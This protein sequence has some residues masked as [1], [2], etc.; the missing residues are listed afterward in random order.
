MKLKV[1][2]ENYRSNDCVIRIDDYVDD[3]LNEEDDDVQQHLDEDETMVRL[4][5]IYEEEVDEGDGGLHV[6][7]DSK[8]LP[9]LSKD[10][11][12]IDE[13]DGNS[14][15]DIEILENNKTTT[16]EEEEEE[17]DDDD[18]EK[19]D[20]GEM[21]EKEK[22]DSATTLN[23]KALRPSVLLMGLKKSGKT[24]IKRVVF[25]QESPVNTTHLPPTVEVENNYYEN[26]SFIQLTVT[27]IPGQIELTDEILEKISLC[28][29]LIY[30][31]DAKLQKSILQR[32]LDALVTCISRG[33]ELNTNIRFEILVHKV[34]GLSM[35]ERETVFQFIS[36]EVYRQLALRNIRQIYTNFHLTSIYDYSVFE[37]FSKTIQRIT[38]QMRNLAE[39][40]KILADSCKVEKCFLFDIVSRIY[41]ATDAANSCDDYIF[42]MYSNVIKLCL[43]TTKYYDNKNYN[44]IL[45]EQQQNEESEDKEKSTTTSYSTTSD[46]STGST[47]TTSTKSSDKSKQL[48][49]FLAV[50]RLHSDP[51]RYVYLR[52]VIGSL[53]IACSMKCHTVEQRYLMD[54]NFNHANEAIKKLLESPATTDNELM[55]HP[56]DIYREFL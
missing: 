36:N 3:S 11:H 45:H 41:L 46:C 31:I 52:Q 29:A 9:Y 14:T 39:V 10:D 51:D 19:E 5:P 23:M 18:K 34:D 24:S 56:M 20:E 49:N 13:D 16:D 42:E 47:S 4:L 32:S 38:P 30:V 6:D 17:G 44:N 28:N 33:Y 54:C 25:Y 53:A 8:D 55:K 37:A 35:A 50:V 22:V 1:N 26:L 7:V 2:N 40:L 15:D 21:K 27:E 48:N 43:T 12:H